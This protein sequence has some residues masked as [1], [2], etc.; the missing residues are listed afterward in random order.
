M[1]FEFS[2][3]YVQA[4][5]DY[6][7]NVISGEQVACK[8]VRLAC[9]R[10]L[11]DLERWGAVYFDGQAYK[12]GPYYFD[13]TE[14][15]R[16]CEFVEALPH[17]KGEWA[18]RR[19]TIKLEPWQCFR[20]T[21]IFGWKRADDHTRRFRTAYTEVA[22]K[23][24]KTTTAAGEALYCLT[25]DDEP[26]AEVVSAAVDR[27][28]AAIVWGEQA[29]RMVERSKDLRDL[30]VQAMAHSIV[31]PSTGSSFKPLSRDSGSH[32]GLNIHMAV[33]DEL[34]AHKTRDMWEVIETATGAREQPL[35]DAITTAGSDRAGICF[36]Q[37]TY[38]TK[39]LDGVV[40]D[41]TYWGI[42]YTI[43]DKDDWEDEA[44]WIKA[45][46]NLGV[47]VKIDDLRRK[48]DKARSTPAAVAGLLTKHFNVWV[49][50]DANLFDIRAWERPASEGG[51]YQ[52]GLRIEDFR[53]RPCWLGLDLASKVDLNALVA[54]FE[55]D[56]LYYCFPFL[57]LPEEAVEESTNSQYDGWVRSGHIRTTE[58]QIVDLDEIEDQVR[59]LAKTYGPSSVP[60]DPHQATQLAVHLEESGVPMV[61]CLQSVRNLSEPTKELDALIRE[62]KIRHDGNPVMAWMISNVV[63]HYDAKDN[64][65]PKKQYP[66][67]KID[68]PVAL[69]MALGMAIRERARL[70]SID[71]SKLMFA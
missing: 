31:V 26:G 48:V 56:G 8:W 23:N 64:V 4:A 42:I 69:I 33:V 54:L 71:V 46:P 58:G 63:G 45:N 20:L 49:N 11:D 27:E 35:I 14:A 38:V 19:E 28:Q 34:H 12:G 21:A 25:L 30:G 65:Y 47:S 22:R 50:A 59:E 10:Q 24:A 44:V 68:G 41:E 51:C 1:S 43:D 67:N 5:L 17:V 57:W 6:A 9:Q 40:E 53:G 32:D 36:E 16:V 15:H 55:R 3:P 13:E 61:E 60:Y 7:R 62:G 18:R 2:S 70:K 52:P 66:Q 29:K 39:I 37:R